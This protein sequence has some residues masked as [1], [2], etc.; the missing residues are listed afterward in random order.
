M[1]KA[2]IVDDERFNIK[3]L[4]SLL[5]NQ[6]P[7]IEVVGTSSS[8]SQ[9]RALILDLKP[10]VVFLDIQMPGMNGFELL[11]SLDERSFEV[12]FVTAYDEYGI[13]AI[14][15]SALDYLLKPISITEL[16]K[17]VDKIK[18]SINV[19]KQNLRLENFLYLLDKQDRDEN[20]KIALPTLK[21]THLIPVKNIVRCESSNNYTTFF[22]VDGVSHLISKPMYEYEELLS[23]Y[24][25][26]RCHQSHLVNKKHIASILN[27]DSGYLIM[28]HTGIKVP[29]SKQ[30]KSIIKLFFKI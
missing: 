9:A 29:I 2:I 18:A 14:K 19:K 17:A 5:N 27:E 11:K 26:I 22:L 15:F 1:I 10:D 23:P 4:Q 25:F 6:Y 20:E 30:K 16:N 13:M 28:E 8:A 7:E 12:V 24:G 3:N 21:E